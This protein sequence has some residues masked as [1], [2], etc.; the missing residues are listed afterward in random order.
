MTDTKL[1]P[2]APAV[3]ERMRLLADIAAE[4]SRQIEWRV[5]ARIY[6][7]RMLNSQHVR[8]ADSP[9]QSGTNS[10]LTRLDIPGLTVDRGLG[11]YTL[12]GDD[13][14]RRQVA[15][16]ADMAS[17]SPAQLAGLRTEQLPAQLAAV[18]HRGEMWREVFIRTLRASAGNFGYIP[19]SLVE[20]LIAFMNSPAPTPDYPAFA[21]GAAPFPVPPA[22]P[23]PQTTHMTVA[24]LLPLEL[25]GFDSVDD[26]ALERHIADRLRN[27]LRRSIAITQGVAVT[28]NNGIG[29]VASID[30]D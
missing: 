24:I 25:T 6:A 3:D 28:G 19:S 22:P 30:R 9:C 7:V 26:P 17:S 29:I 15:D 18:R 16:S 23:A 10:W 27:T 12:G 21:A 11:R 1:Q 14:A 8:N 2:P 20:E 4:R 5:Q 13:E